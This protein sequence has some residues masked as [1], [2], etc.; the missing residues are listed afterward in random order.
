MRK[1]N[2]MIGTVIVAIVIMVMLVGGIVVMVSN[3]SK[4][5]VVP[6]ESSTSEDV[7][8]GKTLEQLMSKVKYET[9]SLVKA[10]VNLGDTSNL[11][12]ELPEIDKYP[13]VVE[14]TGDIDIEIFTSGEKAGKNNDRWMI[15]VAE[16]FNSSH[17]VLANGKSVSISVRAVASGLSADYI[18]SG[19][20]V[21]DLWTPSNIIFGEYASAN[22]AS[23]EVYNERLVGNTAGFLISKDSKYDSIQ[24]IIDTVISGNLNV[25]YTNPQSS[26]AG[27]N[28][29]IQLLKDFGDGD[30][31]SDEAMTAFSNFNK[32]I[33]FIAYTTQQM[34]DS[35]VGGGL[36][37]M[38]SEYQA[39]IN[40][41]AICD[42]YKF[43]PFGLR[44]DNPLYIV[45]KSGKSS[46]E[47]E[48]IKLVND[49]FMSDDSQQLATNYG[50]NANDEYQS[51]YETNG[52]EIV[53]ALKLYKVHKDAGKQVI[54]VFVADCSGS[55]D[56]D[57]ISRLKQSLSNGM[58]Y[59]NENSM[60]GLVSYSSKVSIDVPI[61][62]FDLT[63]KS[64]FQGAVNN[65]EA[66]GG[67]YSYE[68][69]CVALSMIEEQKQEYPDAKCMLFLLSDGKASGNYVLSDIQYAVQQSG[70]PIYT[71]GYT[72]S[73][74]RDEM[75]AV[76]SINEATCIVA[77]VDD[78]VYQ[79]KSLFNAQL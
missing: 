73:T 75:Q 19:K 72:D 48:A 32:N 61:A 53:E 43:I 52:A 64:Y 9:A 58:Q 68:A 29:L 5:E 4:D 62:P 33:P 7:P 47:L 63:Q 50:F 69:I 71:V 12:D 34:I 31:D 39:Y 21:P 44:H 37:G 74:D 30:I 41:E 20:A 38:I 25:G 17:V 27:A 10:P 51:S 76:S 65:L 70:V 56:G 13:L 1:S 35:A 54:A 3:S 66:F 67:T 60:V 18:I 24:A 57:P 77:D 28:L 49:Y 26:A 15:D 11:Y 40:N 55:M 6:S 59:I 79:I 42:T 16:K 23:I 8:T 45:N 22:G 14:G 46:D 2:N 78:V 36:D